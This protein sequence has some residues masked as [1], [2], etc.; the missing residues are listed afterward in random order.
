MIVL[1]L[2]AAAV[3]TMSLASML[4]ADTRDTRVRVTR[5]LHSGQ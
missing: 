2:I 3:I 5:D 1:E 4:E